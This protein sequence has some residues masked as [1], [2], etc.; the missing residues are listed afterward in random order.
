MNTVD[1]LGLYYY[2]E[3]K[4]CPKFYGEHDERIESC[5]TSDYYQRRPTRWAACLQ[6]V[7]NIRAVHRVRIGPDSNNFSLFRLPNDCTFNR[8]QNPKKTVSGS[9][10]ETIDEM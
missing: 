6:V 4:R 1:L 8:Y 2:S 3:S 9:K 10:H 7:V 5:Q